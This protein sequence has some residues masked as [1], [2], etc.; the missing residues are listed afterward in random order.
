M[1]EA[2]IYILSGLGV[3]R[4]VFNKMNFKGLNLTYLDWIAPLPTESISCYA[5]R[6]SAKIT[7]ERPI[8]IGLSFGGMIAMEIAKMT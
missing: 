8:L 6:L 2:H 4:R 1:S 5:L 7:T 3:D